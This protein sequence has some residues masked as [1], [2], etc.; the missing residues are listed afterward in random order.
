[1]MLVD[2]LYTS[3]ILI[4]VICQLWIN[5][6]HLPTLGADKVSDEKLKI[7]NWGLIFCCAG[8]YCGSQ[9][10]GISVWTGTMKEMGSNL[11]SSCCQALQVPRKMYNIIYSEGFKPSS[12]LQ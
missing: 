7:K 8:K 3:I 11:Q 4:C 12:H 2:S 10:A 9:M 1:M 6:T 5:N